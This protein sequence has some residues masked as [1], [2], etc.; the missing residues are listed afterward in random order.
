MDRPHAL[1][2]YEMVIRGFDNHKIVHNDSTKMSGV[3][4]EVKQVLVE[5]V[6]FQNIFK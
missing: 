2:I 5:T 6:S 1:K 3:M 4:L